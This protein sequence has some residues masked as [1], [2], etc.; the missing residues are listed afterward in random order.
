MSTANATSWSL[1]GCLIV[2]QSSYTSTKLCQKNTDCLKITWAKLSF[3]PYIGHG[4]KIVALGN[5]AL[6][7]FYPSHL[8]LKSIELELGSAAAAEKWI[9]LWTPSLLQACAILYAKSILTYWKSSIFLYLLLGPTKLITTFE[10]LIK[11]SIYL[12]SRWSTFQFTQV[13]WVCPASFNSFGWS[14]YR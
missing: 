12:W 1:T 13:L 8:V 2:E 7:A 6:T 5:A 14:Q 3:G 11:S 10:F 4:L 9:N